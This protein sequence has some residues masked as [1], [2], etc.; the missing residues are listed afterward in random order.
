MWS[1]LSILPDADVIGF[2]IGVP[3]GDP[4]AHR[5]VTH[6]F[7]LDNPKSPIRGSSYSTLIVSTGFTK[8]ALRAG[9]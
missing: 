7:A 1:A 6:S 4:W 5:A 3:Y 8:I 9:K 2:A